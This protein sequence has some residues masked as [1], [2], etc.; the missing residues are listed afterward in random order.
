DKVVSKVLAR[1]VDVRA[2]DRPL[3]QRPETLDALHMMLVTN[4]LFGRMVDSTVLISAPRQR[5]VGL[6]FVGTDRRA[7]LDVGENLRLQRRTPNI[8]DN[9]GHDAP[10]SLQHPEHNCLAGGATAALPA[11][12][13]A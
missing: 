11:R 1:D 2:F 13:L 9:A 6:Q 4:P 7:F 5:G 10:A 3:Q 8:L 12:A